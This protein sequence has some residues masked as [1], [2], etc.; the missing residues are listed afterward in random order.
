MQKWENFTEEELKEMFYSSKTATE[1][2]Q[3]LGYKNRNVVGQIKK[4][5]QWCDFKERDNNILGKKFGRLTVIKREGTGADKKVRWTAQCDCGNIVSGLK[6]ETLKGGHT[7]S[8]GCSLQDVMH[9]RAGKDKKGETLAG[10]VFG[11]LTVLPEIEYFNNKPKNKCQCRCGNICYVETSCLTSGNTK[12]CGCYSR[13]QARKNAKEL[14]NMRF[15]KLIALESTEERINRNI[16]WKCQCDCGNICYVSSG[17]LLQG[18]TKSCGCLQNGLS[19]LFLEDLF[20]K[21]KIS[22]KKEYYFKDLKGMTRPLRFDFAV[23]NK[24]QLVC[25]IEYQGEQHYYP[26]DFFGGE[27]YFKI[28]QDYDNKKRKYCE[29]NNILLIEI[30]YYDKNKINE[31][32]LLNKIGGVLE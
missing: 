15:G 8:C 32:Y 19:T 14:T 25:L 18:H 4:K 12:S 27:E 28:Q 9:K 1:F 11:Y 2:A 6:T 7:K 31:Q 30:P 26:V 29:E 10:K 3:K 21:M 22:Y 24:K 5:Y 13:E 23:F 20:K 16:I 17:L